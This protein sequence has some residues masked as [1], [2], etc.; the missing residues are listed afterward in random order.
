MRPQVNVCAP[1]GHPHSPASTLGLAQLRE[2]RLQAAFLTRTTS[3]NK[4]IPLNQHHHK[5]LP[6]LAWGTYSFVFGGGEKERQGTEITFDYLTLF[7]KGHP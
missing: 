5:N 4:K 1:S 3:Q 7:I 2:Q 6:R